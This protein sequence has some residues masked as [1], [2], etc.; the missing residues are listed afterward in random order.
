MG[1]H[2]AVYV[3]ERERPTESDGP[4]AASIRK[5]LD[6]FYDRV[7]CDPHLGPLFNRATPGD[8]RSHLV[9]MHDFWTS[10]MLTS[11]SYKGAPVAVHLRGDGTEPP[12][13]TRWLRLF[14]DTCLELFPDVVADRLYAK[15]VPIAESLKLAVFYRS[16]RPWQRIAP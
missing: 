16:D 2:A 10:L 14:R 6:R 3:I 12:V 1:N 4:S 7:R 5:L 8:C 15:A 13:F 9:T 11:G